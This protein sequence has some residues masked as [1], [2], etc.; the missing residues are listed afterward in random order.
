[1]KQALVVDDVQDIVD[2]LVEILYSYGYE[3]AYAESGSEAEEKIRFSHYDLLITDIIMPNGNGL[4]LIHTARE[5]KFPGQILAI[6]GGGPTM[7]SDIALGATSFHADA[8]LKKPFTCEELKEVL[9]HLEKAN[10]QAYA[11]P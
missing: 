10:N 11:L 1:M 7:S 4:D 9:D 5:H 2:S 6:S 3:S 8:L